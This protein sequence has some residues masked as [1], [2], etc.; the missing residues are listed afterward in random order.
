M[1]QNVLKNIQKY[2]NTP[3]TVTGTVYT[4]EVDIEGLVVEKNRLVRIFIPSDYDENSNKTYPV[5][6]MMDG[7]NLFDKYTSFA[8]EWGVDEIMEERTKNHKQTYIVVGIDSSIDGDVRC[9]EM[10]PFGENLTSIDDLPNSFPAYGAIL[11]SF[12]VSKLIPTID[13]LY[14]TNN[15]NT[16]CG[17]SMGGLFAYYLG[18]K[19]PNVFKNSIC[20]S[21]AFCLYQEDHVKEELKK[22]KLNT[23]K[24]YLLVG[25]LEYEHQFVSLTKYTYELMLDKGFGKN[26]K[27]VHDLEGI[28]HESFWNK[29]FNDALEFID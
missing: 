7:K 16:I 26:L 22:L 13:K 9:Q 17:S 10:A 15:V 2:V 19:Y 14:R 5:I 27:Y 24:F 11:G 4:A 23:N 28:H 25:N 8:G 21:P 6:Y 29:Y 3:N 20:F 12:I 18:M 1:N